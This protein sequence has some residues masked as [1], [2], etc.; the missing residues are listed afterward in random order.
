M[1][2]VLVL[3]GL[4]WGAL[5][6][7][8]WQVDAL[9]QLM[10]F[11]PYAALWSLLPLGLAV[12]QRHWPATALAALAT[13]L[14][15]ACVLPRALPDR[16]RGLPDRD[17]G[18]R[19]G[20]EVHVMTANMLAGGADPA[21]IVRLVRDHDVVV[22]AL[23]EFTPTGQAGLT[24]AG[25]GTL[26]PYASLAPPRSA[27]PLDTTGSALYSRYPIDAPGVR[28]NEGGFQQAYGIVQI[29][30]AGPLPAESA[31]ALAP[32]TP[33]TVGEWR[34][35]LANQPVPDPAGPPRILLGDFNSTLDHPPF[36]ALA[37]RGYRD[38]AD[39][40]GSGLKPT[41]GPYGIR[42]IRLLTIDHVLADRRIGVTAVS[43]HDLP[44]SD[45]RAVLATLQIPG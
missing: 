22:L 39:A 6:A 10:V 38:A 4:L 23:Q 36:R 34:V 35:D 3:P 19:T 15:V 16:D 25:L 7:A 27:D 28:L 42:P 2:A 32:V 33:A 30:G 26:L 9:A 14:L 18:P 44:G 21:T 20:V 11:T 24:A 17:R 29:P 43:V 31:H 8:G 13:V 37:G 41:W 12:F 1:T 40:V 45:H 5:R